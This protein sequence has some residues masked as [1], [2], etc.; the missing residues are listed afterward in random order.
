MSALSPATT[1]RWPAKRCCTSCAIRRRC[2]SPCS[3]RSSELFMLGY[4]I[5]TNV[6]NVRTVIYDQAGTQES[7]ALLQRF[8][9]SQ[10]FKIVGRVFS[11][12]ELSRASSRAGPTSASRFRRTIRGGWWPAERP[13]SWSWWTARSRP[14]RPRRSTSATRW[15]CRS[16]WRVLGDSTSGGCGRESSSIRIRAR[17]ILRPRPDGG[18]VSDDGDHA[19]GHGVVRE[20]ETGTLEQ[21]FM[22]PVRPLELL[23][24]KMSPTSS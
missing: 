9:N 7:R 15:P 23:F 21:L 17:P 14:W 22:T 8:E 11:D 3:S 12:E 20:K 10:T 4:A 18:H 24:G 13:R 19:V 6:R 5:D 1:S 2:S 16:R